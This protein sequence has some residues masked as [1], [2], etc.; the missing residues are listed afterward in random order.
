M[1][2]ENKSSAKL[3]GFFTHWYHVF[4]FIIITSF[5]VNQ[6]LVAKECCAAAKKE[7]V[8]KATPRKTIGL[9]IQ[10]IS[11]TQSIQPAKPF[12]VGLRI[13]HDPKYHTYWKN[14]GV[15][16]VPTAI[17]WNLPE[18][19]KASAIQWPYPELT[20]M[21]DYPCYGYERDILLMAT[22]TPPAII[23]AKTIKL[24]ADVN[25]MC[26]AEGCYPAFEKFYLNLPVAS[27]KLSDPA[28]EQDLNPEFS[29]AEEQLPTKNQKITAVLM[30]KPDEPMI[31]LFIGTLKNTDLKITHL[32]NSDGQTSPDLDHKITSTGKGGY[33]YTATRS[34]FS[35]KNPGSFPFILQT[36]SGYFAFNPSFNQ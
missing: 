20:K 26:C 24:D 15:V 27:P 9:S 18:G 2:S 23:Q 25:W 17:K 36:D 35:P 21:A 14:P 22:I 1:I 4:F 30:S 6:P 3:H 28:T 8:K 34:E 32:F 5:L 13:K 11:E 16:G 12:R 19:F 10:L 29:L 33:L 31:K 7:V